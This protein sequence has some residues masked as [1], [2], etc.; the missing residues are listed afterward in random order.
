MCLEDTSGFMNCSLYV[1]ENLASGARP[2]RVQYCGGLDVSRVQYFDTTR[3]IE[4][5]SVC[6]KHGCRFAISSYQ[7]LPVCFLF[8][9]HVL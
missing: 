7:V 3:G 1:A 4:F 6:R 8:S 2:R 5:Q 9:C